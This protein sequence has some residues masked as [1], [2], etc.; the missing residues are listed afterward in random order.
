MEERFKK[1]QTDFYELANRPEATVLVL[2]LP[3]TNILR[4]N[5]GR[6]EKLQDNDAN[7]YTGCIR[8]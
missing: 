3:A 2:A 6:L 4:L 7:I 1:K 5:V 8:R